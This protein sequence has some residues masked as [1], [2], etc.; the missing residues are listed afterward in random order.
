MTGGH[1]SCHDIEAVTAYIL[2]NLLHKYCYNSSFP[3][4]LPIYEVVLLY[5][6]VKCTSTV[7]H[8]WHIVPVKALVDRALLSESL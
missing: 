7:L 2:S 5:T 6:Y 4:T 1:R 3:L 8:V